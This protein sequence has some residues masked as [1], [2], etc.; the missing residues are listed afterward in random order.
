MSSTKDMSKRQARRE[1]IRR[2]EQRGRL[3]GIGL[4]SLGA[5]AIAFLVI[6]PSLKPVGEIVVPEGIT[7]PDVKFN[8][9]GDPDAPIKLEEYS[10][11][12]CPYCGKFSEQTEAKLIESYVST[13]T[14]YFIY[15]SFGEF[16]GS[17]SAA[18]AEAAYCAGD[19]EKF[20][21]MHDVI[22]ANQNGENAGAFTDKK[23]LAFANKL[24]LDMTAF[25]SCFSGNKYKNLIAQDG[26]DGLKAGV[27]A[28]PSFVMSYTVNG[29][30]K[31]KLIEGALPIDQFKLEIDAAL[32]EMGK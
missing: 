30:L 2:K 32:A 22:F 3:F 24:E 18:A 31:T 15:H 29:V 6:Y 1:Q 23:L 16:I 26:Q 17:E 10:D 5:I 25:K 4:V 21:Q 11:F 12:Q 8:A 28:T 13:G 7:R 19:Q 27:K 20:W 14:V 9:T